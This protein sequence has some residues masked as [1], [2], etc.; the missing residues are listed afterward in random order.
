MNVTREVILDL[1]PVYFSGEASPAT[2]ALVE[3]FL[4][5]DAELAGRIRSEWMENLTKAAP[6][7][8]PPELELRAFRRTKRLLGWQKWLLGFGIFFTAILASFE[9]HT[10]SNGGFEF[11]LLLSTAPVE[12]AVCIALAV[13]CWGAY[14]AIRRRLR[15]TAF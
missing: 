12:F 2:K 1:L 9:F 11:H 13:A 10:T 15:T 5:Q 6:S 14:I 8:L 7:A 3:E 4:K